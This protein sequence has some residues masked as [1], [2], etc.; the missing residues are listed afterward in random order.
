MGNI[1]A[2]YL[3]PHPPII[4]PGIGRGEELKAKKTI[5]GFKKLSED[6]RK[7]APSTI[8]AI[9]PH[10]P[11]FSDA[12][13][14]S[15]E[16]RLKGDFGSFGF[17]K[18]KFQFKNNREMVDAIIQESNREGIIVAEIDKYLVENYD[19]S[20]KLDHG[21]LVPLY[22]VDKSYKDFK[23][24]HITYGML[25]PIELYRFGM[26]IQK[27]IEK[28]RE[29]VV[30]IASGD[31]S[32]RLSDEGPYPYSPYGK[33]FDE[34]I[35]QILREGDMESIVEFDLS[36][37]ERAGECGLRSLM[38][39]AGTM[40]GLTIE[41][42]VYSYEGPYGV[43]YATAQF[44]V[45]GKNPRRN[46]LNKLK[47]R[48]NKKIDDIRSNE[49]AY[50]RLARRSVEY[51]IQN[52]I[53]MKVPKDVPKEMLEERKAVF[54]TLYKDGMLRGCIGTTEPRQ[55]N[56]AAEIITNAVSA[57]TEDPRFSKV[58][59]DELDSIIYSVDVL[60]K[61]EPISSI[62]ELD[63]YNYGVIVKKGYRQGLLLPN[64]QG[65]DTVEEQVSIALKKAG[66]NED[67]EYSMERFKVIRHN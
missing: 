4:L 51:Y 42:R 62:D 65:V 35:V 20:D 41:P 11:L 40:D 12:I 66:I 55:A 34:K 43:G 30:V 21:V 1:L 17:D 28:S 48:A 67:E 15:I 52:R 45:L 57:A 63:V 16:K 5:E 2:S 37:A 60:S 39:M 3:C 25:S 18:I 49:D 7:K 26:V 50:A 44:D 36:L 9:T 22:F 54:V 38:I 10:G 32:H 29:D 13:S 64:I 19:I 58:G 27:V 33:E 46:I 14:I 23:L 24:I 56:I 6:I 47:L 8:I 53:H 31:L 59:E 61:P